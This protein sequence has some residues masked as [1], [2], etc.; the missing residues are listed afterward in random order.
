MSDSHI[1]SASLFVGDL[2]EDCTEDML[3]EK[4]RTSRKQWY[5]FSDEKGYFQEIL[6]YF[7]CENCFHSS[8]QLGFYVRSS[9]SKMRSANVHSV[10]P[11]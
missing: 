10:S 3:I 7:H 8:D 2:A 5:I 9:C 4:V 6:R 11:M 1:S